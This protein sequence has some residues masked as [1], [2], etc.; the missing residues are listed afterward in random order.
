MFVAKFSGLSFFFVVVGACFWIV[1][2]A[3]LGCFFEAKLKNASGCV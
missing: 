3:V 2:Q 1:G